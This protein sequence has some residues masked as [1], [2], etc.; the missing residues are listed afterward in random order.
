MNSQFKKLPDH[1]KNGQIQSFHEPAIHI[2]NELYKR[3]RESLEQR[4]YNANNAAIT[5]VDLTEVLARRFRITMFLAQSIVKSLIDS[6]EIDSFVG[7]V[8]PKQDVG[9]T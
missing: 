6:N 7:Y 1:K 4:G 2:L 9:A 5:K 3:N 8:K